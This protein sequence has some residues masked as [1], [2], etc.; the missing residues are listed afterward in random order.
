MIVPGASERDCGCSMSLIGVDNRD[1]GVAQ[2][3]V[4]V[5]GEQMG[6]GMRFHH[7]HEPRVMHLSATDVLSRNQTQPIPEDVRCVV[8]QGE[9]IT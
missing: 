6:D 7:R 9:S 4:G 1:R 2:E 5:E 3:V 8:K